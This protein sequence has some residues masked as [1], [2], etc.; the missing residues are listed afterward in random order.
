MSA[1]PPH[2]SPVTHDPY[3]PLFASLPAPVAAPETL[4]AP[5]SP[6]EVGGNHSVVFVQGPLASLPPP[7]PPW[8]HSY[9]SDVIAHF[10][11]SLRTV[12]WDH[13]S[14]FCGVFSSFFLQSV[15]T[16]CS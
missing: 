2:D 5:V 3:R 1:T 15:G 16:R 9:F 11:L 14:L 7:S 4:A 10:L 13:F 6:D 8:L 12:H